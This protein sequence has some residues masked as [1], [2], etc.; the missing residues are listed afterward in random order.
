[1]TLMEKRYDAWLRQDLD[2]YLKLFSED[3]VF[4]DGAEEGRGRESWGEVNRSS[5]ERY[6]PVSWEIHELAVHGSNILAEW[7]VTIAPR[8]A[9]NH[10]ALRGMSISETQDGLLT[11]NREYRWRI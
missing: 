9:D 7:T 11:S 6:S 10:V 3:F 4:T 2:A 8:G 1:M 5:Y